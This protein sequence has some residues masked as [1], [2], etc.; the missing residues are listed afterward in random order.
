MSASRNA[1]VL[2]P[3]LGGWVDNFAADLFSPQEGPTFDFTSPAGEP[4]LIPADS[5]SWRVFR[6]PV[7]LFIGGVTAVLLELAEPRVRDGVWQNSSFRTEPMGRLQRTGLAAMA[8]VYGARSRAEAMI[9]GVGR[10]HAQVAGRTSEGQAYRADDPELLDWVQ[11]TASFGFLSAYSAYARRLSDA[12]L[13]QAYAEGAVPARLYGAD[14][15]PTS[16]AEIEALFDAMRGRLVPSPIV[17]EF[18][19]IMRTVPALPAPA[20]PVQ[21]LLLKAAVGI[22]PLW[23]RHRLGL[24]A[25]WGLRGW[26]RRLV[27]LLGGSGE[28]LL[29]R[30]SPAVQACRRL[31]LPD[32]YLWTRSR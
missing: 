5:V 4:A 26:E 32:D 1:I 30:A 27:R 17:F 29:I 6:N 28:R 15:A 14:G 8:T 11:A 2:P 20:R 21:R 23:V 18:L 10:L 19:D 12:E 31:G 3:P 25:D 9:A 22:L 16:R 24:G 7:T 13:D